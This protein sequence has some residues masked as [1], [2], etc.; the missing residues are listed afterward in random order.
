MEKITNKQ[1]EQLA[2]S[3]DSILQH[4]DE[5]SA[6]AGSLGFQLSYERGSGNRYLSDAC[7]NINKAKDA[8]LN[9]YYKVV[10][11]DNI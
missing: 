2:Q 9:Q 7:M 4:I 8:F 10:Q 6:L 1:K 11:Q 3:L 5:V